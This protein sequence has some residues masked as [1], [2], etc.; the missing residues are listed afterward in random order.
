MCGTGEEYADMV[1][2]LAIIHMKN[3]AMP[4]ICF[5]EVFLRFVK[6]EDKISRRAFESMADQGDD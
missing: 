3:K 6:N 4:E 5:Q 1:Y 2:R